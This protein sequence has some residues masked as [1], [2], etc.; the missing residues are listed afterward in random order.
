MRATR[1]AVLL[2]A[3]LLHAQ[4]AADFTLRGIEAFHHGFY[5]DAAAQFEKAAALAPNDPRIR[6]FLAL[7]QAGGGECA[8]ASAELDRQL[9]SNADRELRRLSGL[10]LAQCSLAQDKFDAAVAV[11]ARLERDFPTDP[12][13]LY[14]TARVHRKAWNDAVFRMYQKAPASYRVN[15]LSAEI[16][17]TGGRYTEAITEYRKAI[18]K[19]PEA[20]I[21]HYRL[22]RAFLLESHEP[23][24]LAAARKE[25]EAELALNPGDAVAVYQVAQIL[26][27]QQDNAGAAERYEHAIAMSPDFAEALVALGKLRMDAHRSEEAIGLLER[28][29]ALQPTAENAHYNLMLAYRNA[30]RIDDAKREKREL[31]KLQRP[32]EGEFTEF[33]KK[34]GEK[35]PKQ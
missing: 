26:L 11:L 33:L 23:Q 10:A 27:A 15:Q 30:G 19:N 9:T 21:L 18:A 12:D 4:S 32:P 22:G 29:V 6:T 24:A 8:Q 5:R 25:F 14:E 2:L 13:V 3:S 1:C 35:A 17:E 16:F 20:V 31:D 34:L 28:A 7:S